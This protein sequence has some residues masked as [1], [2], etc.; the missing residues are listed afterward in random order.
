MATVN[1]SSSYSSDL[2][3]VISGIIPK[4]A[5]SNIVILLSSQCYGADN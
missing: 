2:C 1:P 4:Q 5:L 3:P